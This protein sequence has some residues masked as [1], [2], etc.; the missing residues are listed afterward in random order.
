M[1]HRNALVLAASLSLAACV[2]LAKVPQVKAAPATYKALGT[3]P[4]WSL[5]IRRDRMLFSRAGEQDVAVSGVVSRASFNG[6]RYV[7]KNITADV[8]FTPSLLT[9]T[10]SDN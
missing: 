10:S 9:M 2:T 6:W 8:T 5:E 1:K 4:F 3:E 7:S